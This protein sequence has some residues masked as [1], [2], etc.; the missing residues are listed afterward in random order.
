M[1][2]YASVGTNDPERSLPFYDGLLP[3]AG[4][5]KLFDMPRGRVYG[6]PQTGLFGVFKPYDGEAA[7]AANGGMAGFGMESRAAVDAFHAAALALGGRC[8]GAPG[9]RGPEEM[10]AYFAYVRDPEGNKLCAFHWPMPAP[11][12]SA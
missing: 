12:P 9:L 10:G 1:A 5:A 7:V 11:A 8:E 6:H 2:R 3:T 4:Y